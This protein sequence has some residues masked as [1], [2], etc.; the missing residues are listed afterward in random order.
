MLQHKMIHST[1]HPGLSLSRLRV[2]LRLHHCA[3]IWTVYPQYWQ[4]FT[5]CTTATMQLLGIWWRVSYV[6]LYMTECIIE[7]QS[8]S[9]STEPSYPLQL[10]IILQVVTQQLLLVTGMRREGTYVCIL[11]RWYHQAGRAFTHGISC[12][13]GVLFVIMVL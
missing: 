2:G 10:E 9:R 7:L 11:G 4:L 5:T 6:L 13:P 12:T 3:S 1:K 8:S